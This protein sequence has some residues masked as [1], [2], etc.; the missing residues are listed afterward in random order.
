MASKSNALNDDALSSASGGLTAHAD[1]PEDKYTAVKSDKGGD[2]IGVFDM[3]ALK[4][5]TLNTV[6]ANSY[7][8]KDGLNVK[9]G[10]S[11]TTNNKYNAALKAYKDANK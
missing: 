2:P 8:Q 10:D 9:F 11:G 4:D 7:G 1:K 5:G 3:S 6:M